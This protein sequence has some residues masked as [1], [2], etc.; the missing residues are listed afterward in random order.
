[1]VAIAKKYHDELKDLKKSVE[2]SYKYFESA[3]KVF[4]KTRRFVLESN[5]NTDDINTLKELSRPVLQFNVLEAYISRLLGEFSKQEPSLSVHASPTENPPD[6][7][8]VDAV[9][10]H[11]RT[12]FDD[13][14]QYENY[15]D[16]LTG[17]Y[18]AFKLDYEYENPYSFN[19]KITLARVYDPMLVGFDPTARKIHKGDGDYVYEFF[20]KTEDELKEMDY[21]IDLSKESSSYV[22]TDSF[23][24]NGLKWTYKIG[25]KRIYLLCDL[26]KKKRKKMKILRLADNR[27]VTE[28]QY[29]KI[30]KYY[31]DN[32]I[33]QPPAVVQSR[34]SVE[35]IICRY[36]FTGAQLLEYV[37]TD[38][39][40]LPIIFG[41]G[42][43]AM[44]SKEND[45]QN[46]EQIIK[47]YII[48]AIDAQRL[49]NM[50]GQQLANH[51]ET[52][53][54]NKMKI[55]LESIPPQ[56]IDSYINPQFIGN[57]IYN[58]FNKD[59][60]QL[61]VPQEVTKMPLP[62]E[63]LGTFN[64]CDQLIQTTL[65]SYDA[66]LGIN[67]NQLSG[68]AIVE[69]A[70]QSNAAA[71][72][73]IANWLASLAHA[74]KGILDLIPKLYVTPR[75]IPI[76]TSEN[77]RAFVLINS[78]NVSQDGKKYDNKK[79]I[80]ISYNPQDLNVTLEPGVN[81]EVQQQ[82]ALDTVLSL[83]QSLPSFASI[84][85]GKGLPDLI[86]NLQI[87]GADRWKVLAEQQ[88][89]MQEEAQKK[90]QGQPPFNP[91]V[92][93]VALKQQKMMLDNQNKQ[94]EIQLKGEQLQLDKMKIA[95][96]LSASH[97]DNAVQIEKLQTERA[98][99]HAD[100]TLKAHDQ[101]HKHGQDAINHVKDVMSMA[102]DA[103]QQQQE[104]SQ[105][106]QTQS[107]EQG[108]Q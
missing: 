21:D 95:A 83:A 5:L 42:N 14:N 45:S 36:T 91:E 65:G 28:K 53:T 59:G 8:M 75:S 60:M 2:D 20:P 79:P 4:N 90:Q 93:N 106:A 69:G 33:E 35:T 63:V 58:Q 10:G 104:M 94:A 81:F 48:N 77:K 31:E 26:Y 88:I 105:A 108:G 34:K 11:V 85:N 61:N 3:R 92:Q 32:K 101:L 64:G 96:D 103:N 29:E 41:D 73:Y 40:I 15:R 74:A 55:A 84:V 37:E 78:K 66:S 38:H 22:F 7:D 62:P 107:Q 46:V 50:T 23:S 17:G 9:E 12:I 44:L 71:M 19:H 89:E 98:V 76:I 54:E 57:Y 86:G 6:A 82:R 25:G 30:L 18:T 80:N 27:T 39:T 97:Q 70:T 67:K 47:P 68:I 56:Y 72:P 16:C 1:M 43:S 52:M 51:I 13:F 100:I 99:H 24:I 49:K 87:R 102:Q